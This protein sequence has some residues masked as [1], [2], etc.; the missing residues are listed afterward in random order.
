MMGYRLRMFKPMF[1]RL[2]SL[3]LM[4]CLPVLADNTALE[5]WLKRQSTIETM[6]V[7]FV[8]ERKL[9]SLKQPVSTPGKLA[10]AKPGRVRWQLGD[11]LAT[12]VLS[13]GAAITMIDYGA[14]SA[15]RIPADSPQAARFG[16]LTG[17]GFQSVE[18]FHA[19]FEV[20]AHR[21]ESGIHQY[22]LR[23]KERKTRAE[24]PWVFLDIDPA[25]HDLR[26][27]ELE[28]R[29]GS[30][31]RTVFQKPRLNVSLPAAMFEADLSGMTV[32]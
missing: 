4:T 27:M 32:K 6:E 23:P 21:V 17:H 20:A 2:L 3:F 8:Q 22:T 5:T 15:R 11:P 7:A 12:L 14:K 18:N 24:V 9:P 19:M 26:A 10:F 1:P 29:D 31:I 30:R 13:D 16:M 25:G 28:A